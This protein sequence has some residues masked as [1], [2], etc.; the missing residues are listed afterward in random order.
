M[1][2][3]SLSIPGQNFADAL[4]DFHVVSSRVRNRSYAPRGQ[5]ADG[6]SVTIEL[7]EG[8][9]IWQRLQSPWRGGFRCQLVDRSKRRD[10]V[11]RPQAISR[12]ATSDCSAMSLTRSSVGAGA[13]RAIASTPSRMAASAMPDSSAQSRILSESVPGTAARP[14]AM[15]SRHQPRPP[16]RTAPRGADQHDRDIVAPRGFQRDGRHARVRE[17]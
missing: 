16:V 6:T 4:R 3:L 14:W 8:T 15:I 10:Q 1:P 9:G 13:L 11:H 5:V 2:G 17:Q 12:I 7:A